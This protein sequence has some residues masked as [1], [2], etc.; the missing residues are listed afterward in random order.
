MDGTSPVPSP[1]QETHELGR[2]PSLLCAFVSRPQVRGLDA[3]SQG[4]FQ[5][6]VILHPADSCPSWGGA[7]P[8]S[9]SPPEGSEPAH[10]MVPGTAPRLHLPA[11]A[12]SPP[13]SCRSEHVQLWRRVEGYSSG[14]QPCHFTDEGT[15]FQSHTA[16]AG[17]VYDVKPHS[18]SL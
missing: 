17:G 5:L 7:V 18:P 9:C 6:R 13:H 12:A 10:R 2:V 15:R 3:C 11:G 14:G 4:S 1:P 16:I 8:P